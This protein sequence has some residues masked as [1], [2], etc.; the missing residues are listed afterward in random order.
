MNTLSLKDFLK[1]YSTLNNDFIDD[2]YTIYD[3]NEY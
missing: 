3:F 1:K 2:F